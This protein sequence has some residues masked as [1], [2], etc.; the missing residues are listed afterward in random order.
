MQPIKMFYEEEEKKNKNHETQERERLPE[1]SQLWSSRPKW[2]WAPLP[3]P[4]MQKVPCDF[5]IP[6]L[7]FSIKTFWNKLLLLATKDNL[8]GHG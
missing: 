3:D 2:S 8:L 5:A 1:G 4:G 7:W 6:F